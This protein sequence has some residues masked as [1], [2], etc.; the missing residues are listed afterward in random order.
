[1]RENTSVRS[2]VCLLSVISL[3]ISAC[4]SRSLTETTSRVHNTVS[5]D[6]ASAAHS[7]RRCAKSS[8]H[9]ELPIFI[10]SR[11]Q[12]RP[13]SARRRRQL[14]P[15]LQHLRHPSKTWPAPPQQ[16]PGTLPSPLPAQ[17]SSAATSRRSRRTSCRPSSRPSQ[18]ST[19]GALWS[20]TCAGPILRYVGAFCAVRRRVG[21]GGGRCKGWQRRDDGGQAAALGW[22]VADVLDTPRTASSVGPSTCPRTRSIRHCPVFFRCSLGA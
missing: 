13:R 18:S 17:P 8:T 22:A 9:F 16:R 6:A 11:S 12:T 7:R 3:Y 1:M 4:S 10:S 20:W 15:P 19:R 21:E 14:S 2:S 5:C